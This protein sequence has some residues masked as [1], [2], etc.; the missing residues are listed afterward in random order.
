MGVE[1]ISC[2]ERLPALGPDGQ[3]E[4]VLIVVPDRKHQALPPLFAPMMVARLTLREWTT[5][6]GKEISIR[7]WVASQ[8]GDDWFEFQEIAHW[9]PLPELPD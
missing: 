1:W 8:S 3:S 9:S 5:H 4:P 7:E 6:S 2:A